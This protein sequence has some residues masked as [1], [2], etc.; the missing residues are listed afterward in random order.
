[1]TTTAGLEYSPFLSWIASRT[2]FPKGYKLIH[3]TLL[4]SSRFQQI[5]LFFNG[6]DGEYFLICSE[7]EMTGLINNHTQNNRQCKG[8]K[9]DIEHYLGTK[10]S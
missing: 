2:S 4:F 6:R 1:M 7:E 10:F 3:N 9:D 5:Q 8:K